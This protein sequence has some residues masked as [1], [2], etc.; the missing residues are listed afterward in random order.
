MAIYEDKVGLENVLPTSSWDRHQRDHLQSQRDLKRL[1]T[2]RSSPISGRLGRIRSRGEV[3]GGQR[4][5]SRSI[6]P[7]WFP[8][9]PPGSV[10]HHWLQTSG[11]ARGGRGT[12]T[13]SPATK[14]ENDIPAW[15]FEFHLDSP[16][17]GIEKEVTTSVKW[18]SSEC[19]CSCLPV[20]VGTLHLVIKKLNYLVL[21]LSIS[22]LLWQ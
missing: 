16:G 8:S 4:R 21:N 14:I 5:H 7:H 6:T 22:F 18:A 10:P 17:R 9:I 12:V 11:D 3:M 2:R 1:A 15:T 13:E 20:R 19:L